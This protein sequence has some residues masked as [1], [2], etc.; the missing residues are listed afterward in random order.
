MVLS[1]STGILEYFAPIFAFL[2]V[3]L[4]LYAILSSKKILGE[5]SRLNFLIALSAGL[6]TL[7]SAPVIGLVN[8]MTPWIVFILFILVMLFMI[9]GYFGLGD[10]QKWSLIGGP[11]VIYTVFIVLLIFGVKKVIGSFIPYDGAG[12]AFVQILFHPRVLGVIVILLVAMWTVQQLSG[13][14]LRP[15]W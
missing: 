4:I 12:D 1:L 3:T 15:K 10:E 14:D 13:Q 7:F 2:L 5:N 8:Y 9:Y 11:K 6:L